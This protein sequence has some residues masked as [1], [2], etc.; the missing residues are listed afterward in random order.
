MD[1]E[2]LDKM[3]RGYVDTLAPLSKDAFYLMVRGFTVEAWAGLI[4][5]VVVLLLSGVFVIRALYKTPKGDSVMDEIET[6]AP[7]LFGS[8]GVAGATVGIFVNFWA[9]AL[10]T[11]A[12][13]Y[14]V[15]KELLK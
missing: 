2:K 6:W 1:F 13:E 9:V 8:M 4:M 12:P 14:Y 3:I 5:S 15:V 11:Y 10:L 7:F